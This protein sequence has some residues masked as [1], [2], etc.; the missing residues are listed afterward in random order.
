[1]KPVS[2]GLA[3][4]LLAGCK[5]PPLQP[6]QAVTFVPL[7]AQ[8]CHVT[9]FASDMGDQQFIDRNLAKQFEIQST[10]QGF[11]VHTSSPAF[12]SGSSDYIVTTV[13]EDWL[14]ATEDSIIRHQIGS[15]MTIARDATDGR[16]AAQ[17]V[18]SVSATSTQNVWTLSCRDAP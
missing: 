15:Q 17:F 13:D 10:D 14:Y 3:M 11:V 2:I 18:T 5:T 16:R 1:M 12:A 8:S 7:P 6:L 4:V 9:D